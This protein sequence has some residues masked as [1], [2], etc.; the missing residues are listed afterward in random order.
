MDLDATL[1]VLRQVPY[2]RSLPALELRSLATN[3]RTHRYQAEDVIFRKGD[4]SGGLCI[5]VKIGRAH[6]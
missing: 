2:F 1:R 6:V 4:P 5:V 3:L